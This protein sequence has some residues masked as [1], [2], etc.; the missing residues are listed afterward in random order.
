MSLLWG[1]VKHG[2][3]PFV[4]G[5]Y[6]AP[7]ADCYRCPLGLKYPACGIACA[8]RAAYQGPVG[9]RN[10]R[11]HR[12]ADPGHRRQRHTPNGFIPAVRA[13]A[14]ETARSSSATR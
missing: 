2:L 6:S 10:G 1:D 5:T 8:E 4:P 13:I 9:R 14:K 3:G 12:R 7:Y 11:D